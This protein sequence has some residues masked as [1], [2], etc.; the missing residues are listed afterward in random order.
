MNK[1]E[2]EFENRIVQVEKDIDEKG[3]YE[4]TE[5]ELIYAAKLLGTTVIATSVGC[6]GEICMY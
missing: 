1:L 5:E 6:F 4:Y 2:E 3:Y